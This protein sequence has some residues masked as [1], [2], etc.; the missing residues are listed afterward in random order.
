MV[1]ETTMDLYGEKDGVH[2]CRMVSKTFVRGYGGW[3]VSGIDY[4]TQSDRRLTALAYT[5]TQGT[6][7]SNLCTS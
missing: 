2:Y 3:G 6:K 7:G 4:S 1:I 5:G